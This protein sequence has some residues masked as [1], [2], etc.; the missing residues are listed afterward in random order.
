MDAGG[1]WWGGAAAAGL[2][3]EAWCGQLEIKQLRVFV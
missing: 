1:W 3:V 2:S